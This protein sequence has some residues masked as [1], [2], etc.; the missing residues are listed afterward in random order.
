LAA[1]ELPIAI[2]N[3]RQARDFA[4]ATVRLAKTDHVDAELLAHFA[5]AVHQAP[6]LVAD[7]EA[8]VLAEITAHRR[9]EVGMLTAEKN[10]LGAA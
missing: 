10:H 1:A 4:R 7:E 8:E 5:Q 3:S 9:Q 2:V 6:R